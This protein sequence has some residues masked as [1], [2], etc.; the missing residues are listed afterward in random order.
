[1]NQRASSSLIFDTVVRIL[2]PNL[3]SGYSAINTFN[4]IYADL[5]WTLVGPCLN[6]YREMLEDVIIFMISHSGSNILNF[7]QN[8]RTVFFN[9][10][11]PSFNDIRI[12]ID[13]TTDQACVTRC[14]VTEANCRSAYFAYRFNV[15]NCMVSVNAETSISVNSEIYPTYLMLSPYFNTFFERLRATR[16]RTAWNEF[17]S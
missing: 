16:S 17:V 1:V 7:L 8:P 12:E 10:L 6:I 3:L 4:P 13:R 15:T 11:Y 5:N 9:E 14:G 2:F